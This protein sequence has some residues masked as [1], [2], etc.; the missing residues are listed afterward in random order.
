MQ[1]VKPS[2]NR[3]ILYTC[4]ENEY[5]RIVSGYQKAKKFGFR[6]T[7]GYL[8]GQN[9][10]LI[11]YEIC[12][13]QIQ[14]YARRKVGYAIISGVSWVAGPIAPMITNSTK[15]IKVLRI[16]HSCVSVG[17]EVFEDMSC[18]WMFPIDLAVF[19]QPIPIGNEGR[20]NIMSKSLDVLADK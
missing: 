9:I 1:I 7:I 11:G 14:Y 20:F 5:R 17:F 2:H 12:K 19:G 16:A 18:A 4:S 3:Y 8:S 15:V 6:T 13:G 10:G